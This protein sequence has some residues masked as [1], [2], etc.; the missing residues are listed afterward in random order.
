MISKFLVT[1]HIEAYLPKLAKVLH[2]QFHYLAP[3]FGI[4][5]YFFLYAR[6]GVELFCHSLAVT[7]P[8]SQK[9]VFISTFG[10]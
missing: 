10:R 2:L 9:C 6:Q 5:T 3:N 1:Y 8:F 4:L 7:Y